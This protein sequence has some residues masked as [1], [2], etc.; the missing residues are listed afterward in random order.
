MD[1]QVT[2]EV[3]RVFGDLED[4][5]RANRRY[6]PCD[7]ILL[8]VAAV[9]CGCE[10]W[11]DIED[12]TAAMFEHLEPLLVQPRHGTPSADTFRR[13]FARLSPERLPAVALWPGLQ[14][15]C[16]NPA[17]DSSSPWMARPCGG[18]LPTAGKGRPSTWSAP[19]PRT[20]G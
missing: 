2:G 11:Q 16:G 14:G 1:A 7:I 13:V 4:P 8:A 18:A 12:W 6:L 10:G 15:G 3:L 17:R 9:M 20:T 5:R 19:M